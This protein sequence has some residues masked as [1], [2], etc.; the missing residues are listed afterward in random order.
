MLGEPL[1]LT[2]KKF[3]DDDK[4]VD[5]GIGFGFSSFLS[6]HGDYLWHWGNLFAQPTDFAK[7]LSLYLGTGFIFMIAQAEAQTARRSF[8]DNGQADIAFCFRMPFGVEWKPKDPPI[9]VFVELAPAM[10]ITPASFIILHGGVGI[11]YF[12]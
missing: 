4:A 3:I 9:G 6:F 8:T 7:D 1:T 5:F 12:M 2:A 10:G 11:R